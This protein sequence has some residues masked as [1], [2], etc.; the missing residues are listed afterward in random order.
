MKKL[1][2]TLLTLVVV[3]AIESCEKQINEEVIPPQD[4][5]IS[6]PTTSHIEMYVTS[7]YMGWNKTIFSTD[8][9]GEWWKPIGNKFHLGQAANGGNQFFLTRGNLE[10]D[11][12]N[13][14]PAA[15]E[16]CINFPADIPIVVGTK[17]YFGEIKERSRLFHGV[18]IEDP[19]SF[20]ELRTGI[21][22]FVSTSGWIEFSMI[23]KATIDGH[24][25]YALDMTF[26]FKGIDKTIG[27]ATCEVSIGR[28][29]NNPGECS[30]PLYY[31]TESGY[32]AETTIV[33]HLVSECKDFDDE[34]LA[35][36]LNGKWMPDSLLIYDEEWANIT[37]PHLVMGVDYADGRAYSYLTFAE[38]GTGTDYRDFPEPDMEPETREFSWTYDAES[39]KL[40]LI[41]AY[42]NEWNVTGYSNDYIIL[43]QVSREGWN[44][45]TIL[46][47][48]AY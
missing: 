33:E 48:I 29:S 25:V 31:W 43:D 8:K 46:K 11:N 9:L 10:Y 44:Y 14:I 41:G 35:A 39:G 20:I 4:E 22:D 28:V 1:F 26:G 2:F 27:E 17:Y 16:F 5:P 40:T 23:D 37:T 34:A 18:I 21:F 15:I 6:E 45:R 24:D 30:A 32:I 13:N 12:T 38:D 7:E 36:S 47:R 42:N 3:V 19:S